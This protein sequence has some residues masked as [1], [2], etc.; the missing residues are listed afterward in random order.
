MAIYKGIMMKKKVTSTPGAKKGI[1]MCLSLNFIS[2][3][4]K[5]VGGYLRDKSQ[6][7]PFDSSR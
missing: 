5:M 7:P 6:V 1:M 3:I 4:Y 2:S